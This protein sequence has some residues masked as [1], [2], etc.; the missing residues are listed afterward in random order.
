MT[1]N[2]EKAKKN[3]LIQI[4]FNEFIFEFIDDFLKYAN[5]KNE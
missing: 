5:N 4:Q 3:D 1:K 2:L